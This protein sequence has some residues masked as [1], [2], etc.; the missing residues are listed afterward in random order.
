MTT[1]TKKQINH[2]IIKSVLSNQLTTLLN[3]NNNFIPQIPSILSYS[4]STDKL[5]SNLKTPLHTLSNKLY[6]TNNVFND[7][8]ITDYTITD[9]ISSSPYYVL[10]VLSSYS[11][12]SYYD[13]LL[14]TQTQLKSLI[15]ILQTKMGRVRVESYYYE[16]DYIINIINGVDYFINRLMGL[17]EIESTKSQLPPPPHN[18]NPYFTP[19]NKILS[20][21]Q[22]QYLNSFHNNYNYTPLTYQTILQYIIQYTK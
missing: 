12:S 21:N 17:L 13:S 14:N 18:F 1:P 8:S 22:S 9:T 7:L 5:I 15:P 4:K 10:S 16:Y 6:S 19:I 11:P 3:L 2:P 20:Q